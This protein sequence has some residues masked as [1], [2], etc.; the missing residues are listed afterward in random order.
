MLNLW[1]TSNGIG[2]QNS[3]VYFRTGGN[4]A[5]YKGGVHNDAQG[6]AGGGTA[7]MTIN[8]SGKVGIGT[9]DPQAKLHVAGLIRVDEVPVWNGVSEY[10]LTWIGASSPSHKDAEWYCIGREGSSQ[11]YKQNIMRLEDDFQK[12]LSL[13][14]KAYQMK[15]GYGNE[16]EWQFGY[17]AEELD[18]L[19]L[20]SLV[21]Y[22]QSGRPDGI[23][24]KKM[25]IY[26]NEVLK[27]QQNY[28]ERLENKVNELNQKLTAGQ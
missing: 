26:L 13:E 7:L 18:Q 27:N 21:V 25:C 20:K 9:T 6:N 23:Q 11:R 2:L 3:T 1:S 12:I 10:D 8:S 14:P 19:G 4:F 15:E 28:L 5:W 17:I 16:D 22:D 24:Y